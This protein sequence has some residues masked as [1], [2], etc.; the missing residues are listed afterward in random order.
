MSPS[1]GAF[2][3]VVAQLSVVPDSPVDTWPHQPPLSMEF[4]RQKYWSG[5]S[6][7]SRGP[8]TFRD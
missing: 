7:F 5:L 8:S 1:H 2:P 3:F 4:F 6:S